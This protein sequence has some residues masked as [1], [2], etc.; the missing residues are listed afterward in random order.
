MDVKCFPETALSICLALPTALTLWAPGQHLRELTKTLSG[1]YGVKPTHKNNIGKCSP[2]YGGF[3]D[4]GTGKQSEP[5]AKWNKKNL[6]RHLTRYL[7][8]RHHA[9]HVSGNK[10][11]KTCNH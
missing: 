8:W 5:M 11:K 10:K 9:I 4:K 6:N 3:Q 7:F 2:A 1:L